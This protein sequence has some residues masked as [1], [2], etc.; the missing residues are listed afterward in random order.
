MK[1]KTGKRENLLI[2]LAWLLYSVSYLGKVNYA[3]NITQIIDFYGVTKAEAGMASTFF[4]FAYGIGQVING[5]FCKTYNIKWAIFG[6]MAASTAVN[7]IV[8]LGV[9]FSLIK[10]L[11]LVNGI[12]LSVLWP[13]L[14]RMLAEALPGRALGRSSAVMGTTVG[15]G[16]LVIYGLSAVYALFDSFQLAF[17]TAAAAD[18]A[19]AVLW[20]VL[21]GKATGMAKAERAAD[22]P[23]VVRTE[24]KGAPDRLD[25]VEHRL[26]YTTVGFLCLF[27]VGI[28]LIKDGLTTWVPSILKETYNFPDALS[29]LLTL[30]LPISAIFGNVFALWMHKKVPDYIRHSGIVFAAM[31]VLIAGLV[32]FM[33][34]DWAV[35]L[36]VGMVVVN[37]LAAGLNNLNT[38]IYPMF[39]REKLNSG[40]IAG[41]LNGF[42]Y[43]GSTISAYG[44]GVVAD[45]FGWTAVFWVLFGF[46]AIAVVAWGIYAMITKLI[47]LHTA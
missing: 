34:L 47:R 33:R 45:N 40:M 23:E 24:A 29:I 21:Y 44:L 1:T 5:L 28:N 10:W 43:V 27:S 3:A 35:A 12:A 30:F 25:A 13:T 26:I 41:V 20:I 7:L 31:G 22:A 11:W 32:G 4:F 42:C 18:A 16:T 17:F 38:S 39:M 37:Y 14:V 8:A 6:S 2:F 9:E 15:V 19:V 36:L 46:C